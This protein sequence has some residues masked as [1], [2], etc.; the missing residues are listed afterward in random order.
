VKNPG[1]KMISLKND[2]SK[3]VFD[4]NKLVLITRFLF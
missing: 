1:Q 3:Y 2:C 4:L